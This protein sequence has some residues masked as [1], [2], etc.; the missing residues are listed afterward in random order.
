MVR[1]LTVLLLSQLPAIAY[2]F[3][4]IAPFSN[5]LHS[6]TCSTRT[7]C[8]STTTLFD[9]SGGNNERDALE[10][11]LKDTKDVIGKIDILEATIKE[12][13]EADRDE[14]TK[15]FDTVE[16]SVDELSSIPICP[17]GLSMEDYQSAIR[18]YAKLP[19]SLK[20]GLYTALDLKTGASPYPTIAQFPEIVS[21]LY[22]TR[23]RL[24]AKKLEDGVQEAQKILN[25]RKANAFPSGMSMM[26]SGQQDADTKELLTKLLDGK[27]VE[28]TQ[29][30]NVVKQ[31]LGR[32]TR[33]E[34]IAATANDLETLMN[35]MDKKLF[36]V[37]GAA[38]QIPGGYVVRGTNT[39]KTSKELMDALDS[40]L[41]TDWKAQV[42]LL[43]DITSSG[44]NQETGTISEEPVLVLLNKD[45]SPETSWILPISTT[46]AIITTFLYALRAYANNASM[47]TLLADRSALGDFSGVDIFNS[48]LIE[49]VVPLVI[50]QILHEL[51]H[52]LIAQKDKVSSE[53]RG[54]IM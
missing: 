17:A 1:G 4:C 34:G 31:Q 45:F 28:Q 32:V 16:Q 49:V 38:E 14:M 48:H 41:P 11:D 50:I 52:L 53:K 12:A 15:M 6:T 51:G 54:Y 39:M 13:D 3:Q 23:E 25:V 7:T 46:L 24:T 47:T 29:A 40:K 10:K 20:L 9:V 5:R 19:L 27:S 42:S 36:V 35:V 43:P 37:R 26:M 2:S 33:K 8:P 21:R 44:L 18:A 30:E 22:E